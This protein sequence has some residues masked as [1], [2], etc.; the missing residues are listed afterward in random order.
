M[1][2]FRLVLCVAGFLIYL[3][4]KQFPFSGAAAGGSAPHKPVAPTVPEVHQV[5]PNDGEPETRPHLE[6]LKANED[7]VEGAPPRPSDGDDGDDAGVKNREF[8][9]GLGV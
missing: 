2:L 5:V 1:S 3:V 6:I 9:G 7:Y 4:V 8:T